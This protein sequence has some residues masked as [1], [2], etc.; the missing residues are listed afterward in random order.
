MS[1]DTEAEASDGDSNTDPES[2]DLLEGQLAV[3]S[4]NNSV[5][6]QRN[7]DSEDSE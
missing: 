5:S 7:A 2:E 6:D 3:L 1:D 4:D